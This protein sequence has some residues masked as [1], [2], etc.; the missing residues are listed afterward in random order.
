[1]LILL[2]E[3]PPYFEYYGSQTLGSGTVA[4]IVTRAFANMLSA[5]GKRKNVCVVVSDLA[6]S[7]EAG[8]RMIQKALDDARQEVGRQELS[9]TPVDLAGNEIYDILRKRLFKERPGAEAVNEVAEAYAQCLGEAKKARVAGRSAEA[10]ADTIVQTYPFHPQLKNI[11]A[12][13]KE[14]EKYRQ[15]RGLMELVSRLLKSVWER[16]ENDVFL[17]GPQHFDLSLPGVRQQLGGLSNMPEV[18]TRDLWD[19]KHDAHAQAIDQD[20]GSGE[21]ATAYAQQVGTLLL[22]ASLS[23]A[24]NA[25][26]GLTRPEMVECL[27]A[28]TLQPSAFM[29]AFEE[30]EKKAWYLHHSAEPEPRYYFDKQEN[31]TKMLQV[32]AEQASE[33]KVEEEVRQRIRQLF[34]PTRKIAYQE[35]LPLPELAEVLEKVKRQRVLVVHNPDG[36]TP[37][38]EIEKF[39]LELPQKNNLLV[40]TGQ[41]SRLA[42]VNDA[43]RY[44]FAAKAAK[45]RI[46]EGHNQRKELEEK[47]A[48]YEQD[49]TATVLTVFDQLLVPFQRRGRDPEL[50]ATPL[51]QSRDQSKPFSGE[52]QVAAVLTAD[53]IKLYEDVEGNLDALRAQAETHLF[54][55]NGDDARWAD[56]KDR[57][58]DR[59]G[60]PWM[61]PSGLETLRTLAVQRD[62]WEDLGGERYSKSPKPKKAAVQVV[63]VGEPDADGNVCLK[64][65]TQNAGPNP[66]IL[67]V[68]DG[69]VE[70]AT[71]AELRDG[72]LYTKAVKVQFLVKDPT[73][74]Y[75][76]AEPKTWV[77]TIRLRFDVD[78]SMS[79]RKVTLAALPR[80][81][82]RYSLDGSEP[83]NGTPYA[84]PFEVP[85]DHPTTVLV[86][87][88]ADGVSAKDAFNVPA[89]GQKK[90]AIDPVKPARLRS[91]RG[92]KS[93]DARGKVHE[94]LEA[95]SATGGRFTSLQLS[96][97]ENQHGRQ[98]VLSG[99]AEPAYVKALLEALLADEALPADAPVTLKFREASFRSG[100]DLEAFARRAGLELSPGEV[101]QA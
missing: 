16:E 22:T 56:M 100:H 74:V 20:A 83:R 18:I 53:P 9:I 80:G 79:P 15:T 27:V 41:H 19:D 32:L 11:V 12:L 55:L 36:K 71:A 24:V 59:C 47:L 17:I 38:E 43:A 77:N 14:N 97:G 6:A 69:K 42:K 99:E 13:F 89:S 60:M 46:G 44:V 48:G 57:M 3:M 91:E 39:F 75:E 30:L 98:L 8:G 65:E 26:K 88:E 61:P 10:V 5:A 86:F 81:D 49:F 73:G 23:D 21:G 64:V 78:S 90:A 33:A 72:Q 66:K 37:P 34:A 31:L 58:A 40:L 68:E 76:A 7:Y 63:Q 84:E 2:D 51:S 29:D 101:T 52:A 67:Y 1:M 54:P 4:T 94:A 93:I 25:V 45:T 62:K 50:R 96:V 82:I 35:V 28:P 87:G 92:M 95:A 85:D 70:E